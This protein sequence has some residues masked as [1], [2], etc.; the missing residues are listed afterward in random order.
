[1]V[2]PNDQICI[3]VV[4][5]SDQNTE[6]K[7][8][9][10]AKKVFHRKGMAGTRMQEVADEAGINKALLHYYFRSK[11]LLFESVFK[12]AIKD[13]LPAIWTVLGSDLQLFDKI[14]AFAE[15]YIETISKDPFIP[16][17]V[18]SELQRDP[19]G[20]LKMIQASKMEGRKVFGQQLAN[21]VKDGRIRT[22]DPLQLFVDM[23]S[24]CVYPFIAKPMIMEFNGL[25]EKK[26]K[27]F[28]E[29]RKRHIPDLL[30]NSIK[31]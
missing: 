15:G 24:L 18:V 22:I 8:L 25:S 6:Q 17:F 10:A 4:P 5:M 12:D 20:L 3:I 31:I 23:M 2:K 19:E 16:S 29:E 26:Y 1:M 9:K 14:R 11:Q 21:A 13:A 30:I 28:I 7:I 27:E